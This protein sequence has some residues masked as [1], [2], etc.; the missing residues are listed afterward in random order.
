MNYRKQNPDSGETVKKY[1]DQEV[2][3]YVRMY[4]KEYKKYPFSAMRLEIVKNQLLQHRISSVFD[5]GCGACGPMKKLLGEGIKCKGVD[6]SQEMIRVGK[7]ELEKDGFDPS[8]IYFGDF[9]H[10]EIPFTEKFEASIALGVFP[11]VENEKNMLN[12]MKKILT[13]NGKVFI[14][15][16]N[17]LFSAFTFNK[18]SLE[19]FLNKLIDKE[20]LSNDVLNE[21]TTF[22][23]NK[24]NSDKLEKNESDKL[25]FTDILARF[26]NP[27]TIDKELFHPCGFNVENLHFY[28]YHAL[29][30][31]FEE[32]F[33]QMFYETSLKLENP[34]DWKGYFMAS[35]FVVEAS[36]V[37]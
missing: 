13:N 36:K 19:F 12:K 34:N 9:E 33:P 35:A 21:V 8:L 20:N 11:H 32:K 5:I 18:Y 22:F 31:I 25:E 30:T 24:C 6:F 1:Y 17:E 29:P 2:I 16:R 3:D 14:E 26:H 27:L 23:K 10:D 4:E 15:F 37:D 7:I 28:H